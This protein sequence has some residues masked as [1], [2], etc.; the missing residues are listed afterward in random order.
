MAH[1]TLLEGQTRTHRG[2]LVLTYSSRLPRLVD[3]LCTHST[4]SLFFFDKAKILY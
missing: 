4:S 1:L 2:A 3:K